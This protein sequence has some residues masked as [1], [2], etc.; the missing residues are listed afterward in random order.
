M[1]EAQK[2]AILEVCQNLINAGLAYAHQQ[3]PSELVY[4]ATRGL[5]EIVRILG[6]EEKSDDNRNRS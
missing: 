2:K 3:R 4:P 6:E 1:T 5:A